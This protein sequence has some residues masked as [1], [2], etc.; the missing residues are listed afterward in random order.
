MWDACDG[1]AVADP[2]Y[3]FIGWSSTCVLDPN[4]VTNPEITVICIDGCTLE[5]KFTPRCGLSI[6]TCTKGGHTEP[7]GTHEY[8]CNTPV[9]VKP[10]P[11]AC[12]DFSRWTG[13]VV[14]PNNEHDNP[15]TV[16]V[17]GIDTLCAHFVRHT[18]TL[19]LSS[20]DCGRISVSPDPC[21]IVGGNQYVYGCGTCVQITPVPDECYTFSWSGTAVDKGKVSAR[22]PNVK[23]CMDGDYELKGNFV[24]VTHTLTIIP[25]ANG[26]VVTEPPQGPYDCG[27]PV[28]VRAVHNE[29]CTF[30]K[31]SGTAVG[32]GDVN[33]PNNPETIVWMR[34]DYTLKA[35]FVCEQ[36]TLDVSS[37][38]GGYLNV[39]VVRDN[40][41]TTW[42]G[43]GTYRFPRG[44]VVTVTA[45]A[46]PGYE[47]TNWSGMVWSDENPLTLPLDEDW[48]LT[49]NFRATP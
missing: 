14:G 45:M 36:R 47:F 29:Y 37:T 15:I 42:L 6:N 18:Y 30:T 22:D 12:Y 19:T 39:M 20:T 35:N 28:K 32:A 38:G 21:E 43:A 31:W 46:E 40:E 23:L 41:S 3:R 9:I 5:A 16:Q 8:D 13:S 33:D 34:G 24:R 11:D 7:N 48:S 4:K 26:T 17:T 1:K 44:M 25:D 49:A 2:N 27:Q 10:V